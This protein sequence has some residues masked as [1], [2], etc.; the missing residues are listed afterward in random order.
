MNIHASRDKETNRAWLWINNRTFRLE[1][2]FGKKARWLGL[3]INIGGEYGFDVAISVPLLLTIYFSMP[4]FVYHPYVAHST[5]LTWRDELIVFE[6]WQ[7]EHEWKR[8]DLKWSCLWREKLK[9]AAVITNEEFGT[10]DA[11]VSMPER[12][13]PAKV[14]LY[15]TTWKYPRW[16]SRTLKRADIDMIIPVPVPGKGENSW[17]LKDTAIE[18]MGMTAE[19]IEEIVL[20]VQESAMRDRKRYGGENWLPTP[21]E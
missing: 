7:N 13:Y 3:R 11:V 16:F 17:D 5:G 14:R 6:I 2:Y 1:Y 18:S 9:G 12:D 21:S 8:G 20:A 4:V 10:Y 15:Q 19:S